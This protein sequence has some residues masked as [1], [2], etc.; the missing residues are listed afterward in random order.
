MKPRSQDPDFGATGQFE[1]T[2]VFLVDKKADAAFATTLGMDRIKTLVLLGTGAAHLEVLRLLASNRRSD[3]DVTLISPWSYQTFSGMTPGF[4]AGHYPLDDC[5]IDLQPLMRDAG[6]RWIS[7]R[8]SGLD[9]STSAIMLD[10]GPGASA[11]PT[12]Q[13]VNRPAML[14]YDL[15]SID[16]GPSQDRRWLESHIPG[17]TEHSLLLY[18]AEQF[19]NRWTQVVRQ[20]QAKQGQGLKVALLGADPHA[21]EMVFAIQLGLQKAGVDCEV[22]LIT[23]GETLAGSAPAGVQ[24]RILALLKRRGIQVMEQTCMRV[25][26]GALTLSDGSVRPCDVPV[27][28]VGV[29][30]PEWLKHS[31]L[32]LGDADCVRVNGRLQSS[33][34]KNVFAAGDVA[35]RNDREAPRNGVDAVRAG[36]D[37]AL[38]LLASLTDQPLSP[39]DPSERNVQVI[40]CGANHGIAHWGPVTAEGQWAWRLKERADQAFVAQFRR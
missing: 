26:S 28:G 33:S 22:C 9:A 8:C 31:G 36:H 2:G 29:R 34:H 40:G 19:V 38:N 37:L 39:H 16:T 12:H 27:V 10:Y 4:V 23:G 5:Q 1:L 7:A 13:L 24:K 17:S 3:V 15:L 20:A 35:I 32:T 14:T 18:P 6:V 30:G 25:D 11:Q 21:I